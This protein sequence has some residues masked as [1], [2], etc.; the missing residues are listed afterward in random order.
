MP[1][2]RLDGSV[3]PNVRSETAMR[4]NG[5]HHHD[6]NGNDDKDDEASRNSKCG[7]STQSSSTTSSSSSS[8]TSLRILLMT[9]R[10]CG[11]GLNLT[12]ADTVIFCEH[13]WNPF[14]DLQVDLTCAP[15]P[16]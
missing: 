12:A 10:A 14:V 1:Y 15:S 16:I 3:P 2:A 13:D 4:F 8:S 6:T 5:D 7:R 9:T 11:L